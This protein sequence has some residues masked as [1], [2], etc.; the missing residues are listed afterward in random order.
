N[1]N[2]P[3]VFYSN[4]GDGTFTQVA[5]A[6][7]PFAGLTFL[8]GAGVSDNWRVDDYDGDGDVDVAIFVTPAQA[9]TGLADLYFRN[10][11]GDFASAS[12][13]SFPNP[14][15]TNSRLV[16]ADFTG[17]GAADLLYQTGGSG[18]S[19]AFGLNNGS[20]VFTIQ[21]QAAS[22]FSGVTLNTGNHNHYAADYDGDGDLDLWEV[23]NGSTSGYFENVGGAF[24]AADFSTFPDFTTSIR[25]LPAD[26]DGDGDADILYQTGGNGTAYGY[27]RSNGDGT[28]TLL[29]ISDSPFDGLSLPD[30]GTINLRAH[31]FND[32]G[33]MDLWTVAASVAQI[34]YSG[35]APPTLVSATPADNATGV[36]TTANIV[37]TFD[38]TVAKGTGFIR[39]YRA[40]DDALIE[41]ID[42]AGVRVTGAGATW[43][44]DPSTTLTDSTAYY[45]Q[46]DPTAFVDTT[47]GA[48]GGIDDET[49]LNFTTASGAAVANDDTG[50]VAENGTIAAGSVTGNDT[51]FTAVTAVNSVG[52]NVGVQIT[53][54]SGARLTLNA[55][56]TYSYDPNGAFRSLAGPGSGASNTSTTDSFTYTVNG[57]DTATVTITVNGVDS[58]GDILQGTAGED[59]IDGGTGN[60]VLN[61]GDGDDELSGGGGGDTLNGQ[62]DDDVLN[63]GDGADKLYGLT[64][65]DELNGGAGND[66][67]F[68][69]DAVDTL[70]GGAGNDMLD[71]GFGA[72]IMSGGEGNDVY[73]ISEASDQ[74]IEAANE[75][76][77]IVRTTLGW[78]LADNIEALELGGSGNVGGT[79]NAGI[80]N[81]Q[82]NAGHNLLS[83]LGGVDTINGND[84]DDIIVGGEGNDL[85]RGGLGGDTFRVA[86]AFGAT[87]ETDQVY[88]FSTAEGDIVDLS[89]IDAIAGGADDAFT[90]VAAFTKQAGQMTLSFAGGITTLKLD[91]DGDG[92]ADYQMKING[93]VTGDSAGWNL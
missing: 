30:F 78:T 85:L 56:G 42:V 43:T 60:D 53:L 21:T 23:I 65:A 86:H 55:D 48:Y 45:V 63:G 32:D 76:Y 39:I 64:G 69:G 5:Q 13:A 16:V 20:G 6:S 49:T 44:A 50:S 91:H 27:A 29:A 93:D 77:D 33:R 81:L 19:Y 70:S 87:L 66:W 52:G 51:G 82:G 24:V 22:P 31:D 14:G 54:P 40:S 8:T 88:D 37:L 73:I 17:D 71:G 74:T 11:D 7:S 79:G 67:M 28:F 47:G 89:L 41:S 26:F 68:G 58:T 62:G 3:Y 35:G 46:I 15:N 2:D 10:D 72:D 4:N 9:G 75:G 38:Q 59:L 80:N 57:G 12:A 1:I 25:A 90:L 61:G 84:G 18:S 36:A 34:F 92:K 83:G